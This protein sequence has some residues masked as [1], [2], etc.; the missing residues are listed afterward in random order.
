MLPERPRIGFVGFGA[1]A[2]RYAGIF[3]QA[4]QPPAMVAYCNGQ[5]NRPPYTAAFRER[6]REVGVTLVDTPPELAAASDVILSLVTPAAALQSAQEMSP[7]LT[8]QHL[9]ADMNN[10]SPKVM[11]EAARLCESRGALFVDAAVPA[12]GLVAGAGAEGYQRLF[13]SYGIEVDVVEGPPGAAKTVKLIRSIL[14]KGIIALLWEMAETAHKA[15]L[16]GQVRKHAVE[17]MDGWKFSDFANR[18][19]C[20][21]G[22]HAQR[23]AEEMVDVLDLQRE[24]GIE[25][26]LPLATYDKFLQMAALN[27]KD[28]FD[29]FD[30]PT[31][32]LQM[33]RALD[34]LPADQAR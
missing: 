11:V 34:T 20:T 10:V 32:Y 27:L 12:P 31:D 29:V 14:M 3:G 15:G 1:M 16:D 9:Y 24:L 2:H 4:E 23:R 5:R 25:P 33:I 26:V 7:F 18:L 30:P 8:A 17:W 13:A 28:H 21:A 22:L 6:A 19:T